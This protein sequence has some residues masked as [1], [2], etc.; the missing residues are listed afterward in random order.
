MKI[1]RYENFRVVL[2]V[3]RPFLVK[4]DHENYLRRMT[5]QSKEVA[6]SVK[7]HVDNVDDIQCEYDTL[8]LCEFCGREWE[9]DEDGFPNCCQKAIDEHEGSDYGNQKA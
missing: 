2:T 3:S 6:K 5:S 1:Q 9:V 7:R 4:P 8:D